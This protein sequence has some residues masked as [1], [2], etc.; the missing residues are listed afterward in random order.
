MVGVHDYVGDN[1]MYGLVTGSEAPYGCYIARCYRT[2]VAL[3]THLCVVAQVLNVSG[4]DRIW[5]FS[6]LFLSLGNVRDS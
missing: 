6:K 1:E 4:R 2:F 5:N 3:A